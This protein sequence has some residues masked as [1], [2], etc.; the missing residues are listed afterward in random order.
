MVPNSGKFQTMFLEQ[1]LVTV[2]YIYHRK[3]ANEM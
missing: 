2:K 3:Q 1:K